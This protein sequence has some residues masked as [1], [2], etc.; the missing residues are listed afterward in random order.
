MIDIY[1]YLLKMDEKMPSWLENY[2]KG[3]KPSFSTLLKSKVVYYPGAGVD[4]QPIKTCNK[5]HFAHVY[6]YVDYGMSKEAT[7]QKLSEDEAI[8]GYKLIDVFDYTER[9]LTPN[10]W[11][12]HY[13]PTPEELRNLKHFLD[14]VNCNPYCV[15]AIFERE[16][17]YDE[18]HGA[19]RFAILYLCGDAI[20]SYDAIFA[21][22]GITPELIILQ[23]H[24]FGGNYNCFGHG[25]A[26]EQIAR[27]TNTIPPYA[28]VAD[29]TDPWNEYDKVDGV[30]H[31]YSGS[32]HLRWLYKKR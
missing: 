13:R 28:L 30:T 3:A 11:T 18:S 5:S 16:P 17:E 4:G 32:G 27:K 26:L 6:F 19:K 7:L 31:A 24:G 21:N 1:D 29:N 22:R 15:L 8:R 14:I 12:Q 9:E 2:Q 20:A 10:G 23:D 25:G